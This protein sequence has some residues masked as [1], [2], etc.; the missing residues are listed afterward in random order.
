MI[1]FFIYNIISGIP[2]GEGVRGRTGQVGAKNSDK[3]IGSLL[4]R[5]GLKR[6]FD[7]TDY[8]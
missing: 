5:T 2:I 8:T 6:Y 3:Q 7:G 1:L 4:E